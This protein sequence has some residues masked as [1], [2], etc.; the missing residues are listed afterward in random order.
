MKILIDLQFCGPVERYWNTYVVSSDIRRF[1]VEKLTKVCLHV[2]VY[3]YM[4]A[5]MYVCIYE[6]TMYV[7]YVYVDIQL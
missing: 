5:C 1:H 3:V 2:C 7:L 6:C 4:C